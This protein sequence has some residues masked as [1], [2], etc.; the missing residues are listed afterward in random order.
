MYCIRTESED[1]EDEAVSITLEEALDKLESL[2]I[3]V[4][5][6]SR[7]SRAIVFTPPATTMGKYGM[8]DTSYK[9]VP[10]AVIFKFGYVIFVP[11]LGTERLAWAARYRLE[12]EG[13]F[14]RAHQPGGAVW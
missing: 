7:F 4:S 13:G 3:E 12:G 5:V 10:C 6:L 2:A 14:H 11:G 9:K 1:A 8:L